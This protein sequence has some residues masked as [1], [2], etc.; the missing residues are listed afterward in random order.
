V[1]RSQL[2]S[3]LEADEFSGFVLRKIGATLSEAQT[4][5]KVIGNDRATSTYPAADTRLASIAK[6]W[7][8]AD[9]QVNGPNTDIA[10]TTPQQRPTY[11]AQN[12]GRTVLADRNILADV[13][14]NADPNNKYY[15]TTQYN[16]VKIGMINCLW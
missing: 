11:P 16:I 14:F 13:R 6:G 10:K 15:I 1:R 5:M 7:K 2:A 3:E 12:M 8:N 4:A 9:G